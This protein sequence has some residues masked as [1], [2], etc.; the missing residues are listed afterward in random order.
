M[1]NHFPLPDGF[2]AGVSIT[3]VSDPRTGAEWEA[4][5]VQPDVAVPADRALPEAHMAALR[6]LAAKSDDPARRRR[7]EWAA[8]WVEADARRDILDATR[9]QA[10]V[11]RYEGERAVTLV[12]GRLMYARAARPAM[13]L[14]PLRDGGFALNAETRISFGT[15]LRASALEETRIDG[16]RST[17]GRVG[18]D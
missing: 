11:G 2:T 13:P 5:G 18:Q 16:T 8:E 17:Y 1:V 9:A 15:G 14:V 10:V 12:D 3:R 6:D 7:L 4:T